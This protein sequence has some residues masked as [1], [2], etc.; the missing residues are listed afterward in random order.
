MQETPVQSLNQED[1]LEEEMAAHSSILP[2]KIPRTEEPGELQ[3]MRSQRSGHNWVPASKSS[4]VKDI[5][6]LVQP[7]SRTLL[8]LYPG[9]I[10]NIILLG[11]TSIP[12]LIAQVPL[13]SEKKYMIFRFLK[14]CLFIYLAAP[15]LCCCTWDL[16][17]WLEIE[18]GPLLWQCTSHWTPREVPTFFF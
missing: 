8:H 1:S 16:V 6:I 3:S 5:H 18:P 11:L 13:D 14:Y 10:F 17:P 2:W 15:G 7:E 12:C 9:I 4:S